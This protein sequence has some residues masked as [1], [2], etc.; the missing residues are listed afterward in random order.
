VIPRTIHQVWVGPY[1][2]P[3]RERSFVDGVRRLN[4]DWDHVLWTDANLP[5]LDGDALHQFRWRMSLRDYAFAA[6]ILRVWVVHALGGLYLDADTECVRPID[7]LITSFDAVFRHHGPD[8]LT[9]SNDF[10]GMTAGHPLGSYLLTT[11]APPAYCFDPSWLGKHVRAWV[12]LPENAPHDP[13]LRA[14]TPLGIGYLPSAPCQRC[15]TS[16]RLTWSDMFV[17]HSL[18]SWSEE[19]RKK[20]E[21]GD[22]T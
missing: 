22:Y 19:N 14:V 20:F 9:L 7:T 5:S 21:S 13:T 8:D 16:P 18:F 10:M 6:D 11:M 12:G 15:P 2:I 1:R 17:N 3:E 4:P